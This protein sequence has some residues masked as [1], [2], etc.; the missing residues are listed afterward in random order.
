MESTVKRDYMAG[1]FSEI[2]PLNVVSYMQ[3]ALERKQMEGPHT[4]A[5]I[6]LN[7]IK[8]RIKQQ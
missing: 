3:K 8:C 5:P 4:K 7:E 2:I 6:L 1:P